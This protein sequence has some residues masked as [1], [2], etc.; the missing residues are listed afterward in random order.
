MIQVERTQRSVAVEARAACSWRSR[1]VGLLGRRAL[2]E[3]E[4]LFFPHCRSIHT[5]GMRF[6]IDAIFVD[7]AWRVVAVRAHLGPGRLL[8]PV[9]GAWGV[10]EAACGTVERVGLNVGDRLQWSTKKLDREHLETLDKTL[11]D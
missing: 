2:A 8:L 9:W 6:P 11:A 5:I 4:A 1:L 10:I 7:R 3:G